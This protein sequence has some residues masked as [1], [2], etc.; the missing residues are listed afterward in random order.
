M[1]ATHELNRLDLSTDG[2]DGAT[3]RRVVNTLPRR[4]AIDLTASRLVVISPHPDDETLGGESLPTPPGTAPPV[5]VLSSPM[6][7]QRP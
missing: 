5:V 3:W 6:V 7:K 2:T 4:S 1:A